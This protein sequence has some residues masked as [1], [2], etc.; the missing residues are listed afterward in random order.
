MKN[1]NKIKTELER[2]VTLGGF[3]AKVA[4]TVLNTKKLSWK[5]IDILEQVSEFYIDMAE[6]EEEFETPM[7]AG[8]VEFEKYR[9]ASIKRQAVNL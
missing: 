3:H 2:I 1:S 7:D 9:Q 5:Q 8:G 6:F 4:T